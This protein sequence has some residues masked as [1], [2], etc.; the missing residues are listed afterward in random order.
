[1]NGKA[2]ISKELNAKHTK[3]LEGLLRLPENKECADCKGRAPRWASVNLG[4][5][6][7]IQCSGVHRSLGVHISKVRSAT[8]DTWLPEQILFMQEMGNE[9]SNSYWEAEL[10]SSYDRSDIEHFIRAKYDEKRWVSRKATQP[11]HR[12]DS[13]QGPEGRNSSN[14]SQMPR[15]TYSVTRSHTGSL[16]MKTKGMLIPPPRAASQVPDF[17]HG[18]YEE[19]AKKNTSAVP[20]WDNSWATFDS[21]EVTNPRDIPR[22]RRSSGEVT[23]GELLL[24]TSLP[25]PP[26]GKMREIDSNN[27]IRQ[28]RYPSPPMSIQTHGRSSS[29]SSVSL[30]TSVDDLQVTGGKKP[31]AA[32]GNFFVI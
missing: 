30:R 5:F 25:T 23:F 12:P 10:P 19:G 4:I 20:P 1:M 9:K 16:D 32:S 11:S 29:D 14:N 28:Q 18:G 17:K 8:L 2:A 22:P 7:C 13:N 6:I 27:I 3:I 15:S 31:T 26:Y 24:S 21:G